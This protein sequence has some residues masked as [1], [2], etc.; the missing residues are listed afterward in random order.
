MEQPPPCACAVTGTVASAP[1]NKNAF[2]EEDRR[3]RAMFTKQGELHLLHHPEN[4][5]LTVSFQ[6]GDGRFGTLNRVAAPSS[7]QLTLVE[8][9]SLGILA[10]VAGFGG[11]GL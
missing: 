6:L 9:V 11:G 7:A 8:I 4:S 2:V 3:A 1:Q 5:G 10:N